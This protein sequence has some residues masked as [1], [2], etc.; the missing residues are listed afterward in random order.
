MR[1]IHSSN[2][3]YAIVTHSLHFGLLF[4]PFSSSLLCS[5]ARISQQYPH[6]RCKCFYTFSLD[7][8]IIIRKIGNWYKVS[9]ICNIQRNGKAEWR[10]TI[11]HKKKTTASNDEIGSTEISGNTNI[12]TAV[13]VEATP[14][15]VLKRTPNCVLWCPHLAS[16]WHDCFDGLV[17]FLT[18]S[19]LVL[20]PF[21]CMKHINTHSRERLHTTLLS[22]FNTSNIAHTL[23]VQQLMRSKKGCYIRNMQQC[24]LLYS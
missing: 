24:D 14:Q 3:L 16:V 11:R 18:L 15:T 19:P 8:G 4:Y 6:S 13:P 17:T 20:Y 12:V 9:W 22:Y 1:L 10:E 7:G 23:C 21:N 2:C 5:F